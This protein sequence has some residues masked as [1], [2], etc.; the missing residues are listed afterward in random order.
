MEQD[1]YARLREILP[2]APPPTAAPHRRQAAV[3][4]PLVPTGDAPHPMGTAILFTQR[5]MAVATHKGQISFPGGAIEGEE[6]PAA[7]ARRETGEELG[8]PP[9]ALDLLGCLGSFPTLTSG[10]EIKAFVGLLLAADLAPSPREVDRLLR[11]PLP[12][13]MAQRRRLLASKERVTT[14]PTFHH[15]EGERHFTIW[16]ATARILAAFLDLQAR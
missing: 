1:P 11:I 3:L 2:D 9:S 4:L 5:T 12:D 16:G 15:Q 14:W 13:L 8:V 6:S 7:A 10:W